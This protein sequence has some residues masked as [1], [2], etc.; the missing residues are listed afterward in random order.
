MLAGPADVLLIFNLTESSLL[1]APPYDWNPGQVGYSN[2]AFAVGG[3]VGVLTAGPLSD[4]E[5]R[6]SD[7]STYR[8]IPLTDTSQG[9]PTAQPSATT[10]S[11]K[12]KCVSR[13]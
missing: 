12:Q 5:F 8:S 10:A 7:L 9:S 6:P 3:L 13:L 2:F 1:G 4:C 11:A